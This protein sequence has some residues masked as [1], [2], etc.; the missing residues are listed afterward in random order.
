MKEIIIASILFAVSVFFVFDECPILY[1]K[2]VS[3]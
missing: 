3:F 1:G 2:G